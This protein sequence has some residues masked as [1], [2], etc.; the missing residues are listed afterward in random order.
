MSYEF[1]KR[2]SI[3]RYETVTGNIYYA[4]WRRTDQGLYQYRN[5]MWV[6]RKRGDEVIAKSAKEWYSTVERTMKEQFTI[7]EVRHEDFIRVL[8]DDRGLS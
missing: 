7:L 1:F 8:K 3:I 5:D 4:M 2:G 6:P